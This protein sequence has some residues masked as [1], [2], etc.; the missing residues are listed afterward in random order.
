MLWIII[1]IFF[2]WGWGGR[3]ILGY[4]RIFYTDR[5]GRGGNMRGD[6]QGTS[7]NCLLILETVFLVS[8]IMKNKRIDCVKS[9]GQL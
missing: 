1:I 8:S 2:L 3:I 5:K 9:L 6:P 4:F 7:R